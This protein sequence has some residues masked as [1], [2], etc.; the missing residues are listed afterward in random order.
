MNYNTIQVDYKA[1]YQQFTDCLFDMCYDNEE[2]NFADLDCFTHPDKM[3]QAFRDGFAPSLLGCIGMGLVEKYNAEKA[4]Y[5]IVIV[6]N[7]RI[8]AVI[9]GE[10]CNF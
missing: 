2:V 9:N 5:I 1:L 10:D 4:S 6:R 3:L 8:W 7:E